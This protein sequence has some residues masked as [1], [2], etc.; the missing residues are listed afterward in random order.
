MDIMG[1]ISF[2]DLLHDEYGYGLRPFCVEALRTPANCR[3]IKDLQ[4]KRIP[5]FL[6]SRKYPGR[7]NSREICSTED[8]YSI[9]VINNVLTGYGITPEQIRFIV[10]VEIGCACKRPCWINSWEI[11]STEDTGSI[12][13]ID[14]ILTGYRITPEKI[15]LIVSVKISGT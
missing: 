5:N 14:D 6:M 1:G 13:V 15:G 7:I 2:F 10:E 8:S 4:R 3:R 11:D 12:H 9:H